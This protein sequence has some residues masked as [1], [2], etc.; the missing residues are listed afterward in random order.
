MSFR[1]GPPGP[2]I[3]RPLALAV[4]LAG[5]SGLSQS[6]S[7][8]DSPK[9]EPPDLYQGMAP[10]ERQLAEDNRQVALETLPSDQPRHWSGSGSG[11]SGFVI[12]LRTFKI[13]TGHYCREYM[14]AIIVG[15][16]S[17]SQ[18]AVACRDGDAG[19]VKVEPQKS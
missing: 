2:R 13:T 11:P 15:G 8:G 5:C 7:S 16:F 4:L 18:V 1:K 19:W 12:P 10:A 6:G 9:G 3:S 14:E 17:R